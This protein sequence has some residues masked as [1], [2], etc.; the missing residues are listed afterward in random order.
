[1]THIEECTLLQQESQQE[2]R[3]VAECLRRLRGGWRL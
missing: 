1:M 3:E 2:R